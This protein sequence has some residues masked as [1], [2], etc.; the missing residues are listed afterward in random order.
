MS[1]FTSLRVTAYERME[2]MPAHVHDC[3]IVCLPLE[4]L[5]L[6]RT[7]GRETEHGLGDLLICPANEEHS[8]I[9]P[10]GRVTKLLLTPTAETLADLAESVSVAEAPY[11][12]SRALEGLALRLAI[13]IREADLQSPLVAEGLALQILGLFAREREKRASPA[14]WLRSAREF[15]RTH[16]CSA[17]RL[18]DVATFVERHPRHLATAYRQ[19]F[20]CTIGEDARALRLQRAATLLASTAEPVARIAAECGY[21]DQAHLTRHFRRA[22]GTT[23]LA[24]RRRLH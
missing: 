20:G 22:F 21:Y 8:Q 1:C 2:R 3:A 24:Y 7:R 19:V 10:H 5:Y 9:F 4:G 16:A 6:E 18:G 17:V 23:P 13:E 12:R 14:P 15:V 11:G